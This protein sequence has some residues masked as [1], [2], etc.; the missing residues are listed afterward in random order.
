MQKEMESLVSWFNDTAP[1]G[2]AVLPALTRAG[3]AHL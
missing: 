1:H 3:I 2:D